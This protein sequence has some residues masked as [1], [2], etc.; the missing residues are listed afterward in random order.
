MS[1]SER[2]EILQ[3]LTQKMTLASD[4]DLGT[5]AQQCEHFTGADFKALLYNAQLEAIHQA[6]GLF[7]AKGN[8]DSP[9]REVVEAGLEAVHKLDELAGQVER[10][11]GVNL[12]LVFSHSILECDSSL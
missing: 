9:S 3:A 7:G 11:E 4:V 10:S 1:Q 12:L 8:G 2:L 5:L 6:T